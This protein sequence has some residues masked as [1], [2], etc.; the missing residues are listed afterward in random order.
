M[1]SI[2]ISEEKGVR[3][4][5]FGS[6]WVQGAMRI[7]R[8]WSLELEY[9]RELMLPLLLHPDAWPASVLQI[10]LGAASITRFLHRYRPEARVTVIEILPEVVAAAR[11]F[12]KLPEESAHLRIQIADGHEFMAST[13][14]RFDLIVVD[15]FDER[16]HSGMLDTAPFLHNCRERLAAKG[17]VAVN[18]LRSFGGIPASVAR[19]REAFDH[20]LVLPPSAAGNIVAIAARGAPTLLPADGLHAAALRLKSRTGL[21]LTPTVARIRTGGSHLLSWTSPTARGRTPQ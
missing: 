1:P 5:H 2:E 6:E 4:L 16:G 3:Y 9:T 18:L 19:I 17:M 15:G 20:V 14:R 7:A 11:Q 10:G 12:F 13:K 21:D 8:P